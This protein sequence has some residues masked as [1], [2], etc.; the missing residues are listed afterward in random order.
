MSRDWRLYWTD[1]VVFCERIQQYTAGME[2]AGFLADQKTYDAV[3]RNIELIGEAAK[4][5]PPEARALAP[6]VEWRA[7]A[8]MRDVLA[9]AYFGLDD[10]ILWD[11]VSNDIPE[12]WNNIRNIPLP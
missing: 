7:I 10:D 5:L 9:H 3:V 11:A 1:I 6:S 8:G 12:L 2:R 4:F